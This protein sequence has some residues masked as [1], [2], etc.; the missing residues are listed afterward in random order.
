MPARRIS[1]RAWEIGRPW[2][3]PRSAPRPS[4]VTRAVVAPAATPLAAIAATTAPVVVHVMVRAVI[5]TAPRGGRRG[6]RDWLDLHRR[7]RGHAQTGRKRGQRQGC[8]EGRQ[9]RFSWFAL[10]GQRR[11]CGPAGISK[12]QRAASRQL[13]RTLAAGGSDLMRR[14]GRAMVRSTGRLW[15]ENPFRAW[16]R[17]PDRSDLRQCRGNA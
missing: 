1:R 10:L 17:H 6:G 9:V 2:R 11:A 7:R 4:A 5:G 15:S 3:R 14:P 8:G 16:S 12:H 13:P